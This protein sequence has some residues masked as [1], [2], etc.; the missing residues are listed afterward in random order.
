MNKIEKLNA[1]LD[2]ELSAEERSAFENE[3]KNDTSLQRELNFQT[4][5]IKGI[6]LVRKAEL[7]AALNAIPVTGS[8][9]STGQ[10]LTGFMVASLLATGLFYFWPMEES[11]LPSEPSIELPVDKNKVI[12][13]IE[14]TFDNKK[15]NIE[16]TIKKEEPIKSLSQKKPAVKIAET[17]SP[18]EENTAIE[19]VIPKPTSI[20]T[21]EIPQIS[22]AE[23]ETEESSNPVK[24]LTKSSV[25]ENEPLQITVVNNDKY[26]FHYQ[27]RDSKLFL[28][29]DFENT[30]EILDFNMNNDRALYLFTN[31]KFHPLDVNTK[32]ITTLNPVKDRALI[33]EL[34]SLRKK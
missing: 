32:K 19:E 26:D 11:D 2:N 13:S 25:P 28:Y 18:A 6:K 10:Y 17:N 8:V 9:I 31:S 5:V 30:Y 15:E 24:T 33:S 12:D 4:E 14:K 7:K 23:V 34:E 3:L 29:G 20:S 1:Y 16:S 27:F 22:N 21:P